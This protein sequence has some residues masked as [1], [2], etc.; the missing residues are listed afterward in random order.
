VSE[1]VIPAID[2]G[3]T[4][5]KGGLV[6]AGGRIENRLS[7]PTLARE[8]HIAVVNRIA[9]A[10]R[11][12]AAAAARATGRPMTT[13][14]VSV[15]GVVDEAGGLAVRAAAFDWAD[16]PM[17]A[18]LTGLIGVPVALGHDVTVG[19]LAEYRYGAAA[20]AQTAVVVPIGTGMAAGLINRGEAYRGA[21]GRTLELGHTRV[22]WA[23]EPCGCGAVGCLE[24]VAAASSIALRYAK[25]AGLAPGDPAAPDAK[26]VLALAEA[27]DPVA[28]RVWADAVRA[29][30]E[31]LVT[32][33]TLF[34]PDRIVIA[35]GLSRAGEKLLGPLREELAR[36]LTFQV[37][38]QV[39]AATLGQDA[40]LVGTAIIAGLR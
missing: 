25:L 4:L 36:R 30:A 33:V 3:G 13:I 38:P 10:G 17:A 35:G 14:G 24:R 15:P 28:A 8:G 31:G 9:Q 1:Q 7:V 16:Y 39:V 12:L 18:T 6:R 22:P 19:A 34:D 2:V 20:G 26:A 11:E 21:H 29:L 27:G 23:D 32:V 37:M 40:G 5:I